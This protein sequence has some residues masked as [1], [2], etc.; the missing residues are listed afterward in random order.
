VLA[1]VF[2]VTVLARFF[3]LL[4][5]L[6]CY[7]VASHRCSRCFLLAVSLLFF[8]LIVVFATYFRC[9]FLVAFFCHCSHGSTFLLLFNLVV[10]LSTRYSNCLLPRRH[11][12]HYSHSAIEER[13]HLLC[14]STKVSGSHEH[15]PVYL[16]K[17]AIHK[18]EI[19]ATTPS[20]RKAF[21]DDTAV[22]QSSGTVEVP[23]KCGI[24]TE[25]YTI[26]KVRDVNFFLV[27]S[28]YN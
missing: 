16:P 20:S 5:S 4:F 18:I 19:I 25:Q 22:V 1:I 3:S 24:S 13:F 6:L 15:S 23:I 14:K 2:F 27:P 17:S 10:T 8:F 7:R 12:F 11:F 28:L 21:Q 26:S 9:Y